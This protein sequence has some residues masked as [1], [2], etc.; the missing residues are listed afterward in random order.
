MVGKTE[1][2]DQTKIP[3]DHTPPYSAE[4]TERVVVYFYSASKPS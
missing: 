2:R 1:I 4:V 3:F